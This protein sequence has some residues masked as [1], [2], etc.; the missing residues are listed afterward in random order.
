[1]VMGSLD[2][3]F[4]RRAQR[5][6]RSIPVQKNTRMGQGKGKHKS[7]ER[8]SASRPSGAPRANSLAPTASEI[9]C[10]NKL[11]NGVVLIELFDWLKG[12]IFGS[13]V[14]THSMLF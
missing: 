7:S 5:R 14:C 12:S 13:Q 3:L 10:Q 6:R 1:M 11:W 2:F 8:L 4:R 9:S